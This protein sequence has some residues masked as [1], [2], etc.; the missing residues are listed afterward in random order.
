ML[1][2]AKKAECVVRGD[3]LVIR[4]VKTAPGGEF[5]EQILAELIGSSK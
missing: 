1:T 3:E 2:A 5:A 4:P